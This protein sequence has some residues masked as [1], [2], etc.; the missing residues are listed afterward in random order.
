M[1]K[2]ASFDLAALA[3]QEST[4]V[5]L[6]HPATDEK[7]YFDAERTQPVTI[8]V[9]S[10]S[11]RAYRQAVNAVNNRTLKRGTKKPS[12]ATQK[13]EGIELLTACCI[14]SE[15]LVLNGSPIKTEAD[16]RALLSNDKFSWIKGQIDEALGNVELFI[17]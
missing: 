6:T 7:L 10:T 3:I 1:T 5:H 15:N 14:S 8:T 2:A 11:S 4:V 13:E 17:E 16:F 9:A 12:A